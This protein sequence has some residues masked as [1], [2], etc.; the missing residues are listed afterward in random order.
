MVSYF[1]HLAAFGDAPDLLNMVTDGT[2]LFPCRWHEHVERW[3]ANPYNADMLII[4]Y[5]ALR[6]EPV[7]ELSRLC[8]FAGL[9]RDAACLK[10]VAQACSFARMQERERALGWGDR[11]PWPNEKAFVR[12]G[13]VGSFKDEMPPATLLAFTRLS[14]SALELAGYRE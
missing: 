2:G 8:A 5:E 11:D 13:M 10:A 12:R 7:G 1:H 6:V 4:S 3:M 9:Q 14:Q